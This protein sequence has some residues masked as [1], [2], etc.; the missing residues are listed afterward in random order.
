MSKDF[1]W[2]LACMALFRLTPEPA[3]GDERAKLAAALVCAQR[4]FEPGQELLEE[5]ID[6]LLASAWSK[7][8]GLGDAAA[9]RAY[10]LRQGPDGDRDK[11]ALALLAEAPALDQF[12][13]QAARLSERYAG[14]RGARGGVMVHIA[15]TVD[16]GRAKSEPFYFLLHCDFEDARR[17]E[18]DSNLL[19]VGDV[20]LGKLRKALVY[21]YYDGFAPDTDR[22]KLYKPTAA[23][24]FD[25]V[26]VVDRPATGKELF[27]RECRDA[28]RTR[29]GERYDD[30]FI[31]VPGKRDLFGPERAVPADDLM[32]PLE[33]KHVCEVSARA[34]KDKYG[35]TIT[36]RVKVDG[37]AAVTVDLAHLGKSVFFAQQG[38][39]R[40]LV[41]K[42]E[43]FVTSD[44]MT[45]LDFA[46][47]ESLADVVRS[48]VVRPE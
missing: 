26:L 4:H 10:V 9:C 22:V 34:T 14:L 43:Q 18:D 7:K 24:T 33:A 17:L 44:Q 35:K 39:E 5:M 25:E 27:Q 16:S 40:Y 38:G 2:K 48:A 21:P 32:P 37:H 30:Y 47:L 11:A 23:D 46:D 8:A 1:D 29:F 42:G 31:G 3:D 45:G 20:V 15:A 28:A 41:I 12:E 19:T 6:R 36:A 13:T